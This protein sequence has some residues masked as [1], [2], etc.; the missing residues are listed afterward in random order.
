MRD[1]EIVSAQW[2]GKGRPLLSCKL[3]LGSSLA[4]AMTHHDMALLEYIGGE[5]TVL[6]NGLVIS[7]TGINLDP[8]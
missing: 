6:S 3:P 1:N 5:R 8:S 7:A 4:N 2:R